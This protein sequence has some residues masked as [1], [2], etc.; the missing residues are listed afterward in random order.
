MAVTPVKYTN[1]NTTLGFT[2]ADLADI[3]MRREYF[4]SSGL[5]SWGRAT[6]GQLGNNNTATT[7]RSSPG[8]LAGL[9]LNSWEWISGGAGGTFAAVRSDG[10]LWTWG[11][12]SY[13]QLGDN[14]AVTKSSPIQVAG[15][16]TNWDEVAV[17]AVHMVG[18]KNDGTLWTWGLGLGGGLGTGSTTSRQS[19]GSLVAGAANTAGDSWKNVA[20]GGDN[21]VTPAGSVS[22]AI[23]TAGGLWMW[24][25]NAAGQL[26]D[27]S[28]VNKSSPVTIAGGG[29]WDKIAIHS[30]QANTTTGH[31][32]G[33]KTDGT[34]WTWGGND[35]GQLGDNSQTNRSSPGSLFAPANA[36]LWKEVACG[37]STTAAI[38]TDGTL[39]TWGYNKTGALGDGNTVNKSSPATTAGGGTNWKKCSM[40][41]ENNGA[42]IKTDGSLWTWG[43]GGGGVLGSGNTFN[44]SSPGSVA[45]DQLNWKQVVIGGTFTSAGLVENETNFPQISTYVVPGTFTET[46]PQ[47]MSS[48]FFEVWAGGGGGGDGYSAFRGGGGASGA[49]ARTSATVLYQGGKTVSLV[50]GQGGDG[51]YGPTNGGIGLPGNTSSISTLTYIITQMTANGGGGGLYGD[52]AHGAGGT[53]NTATGGNVANTAGNAGG[54]GSVGAGNGGV[55]IVGRNSIRYGDGG[56]GILV[57]ATTG[58]PGTN[59]AVIITYY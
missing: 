40:Q 31:S 33:I 22:G 12:G 59:G 51:G 37:Y 10:T 50:V 56:T 18:V 34:L 54:N 38:K 45:G 16:G 8:S 32:A 27:G 21:S 4:S 5:Y 14:T 39:W 42:G 49:Y 57:D 20:A 30:A 44:R 15:G 19:P 28:T 53:A 48:A 9:G 7:S 58:S 24:G 36:Y 3:L 1:S 47:G 55:G 23:K 26:G 6:N 52:I 41:G 43:D 29:T 11:Q 35:R 17:S 46:I 13:G 25:Y 2:G